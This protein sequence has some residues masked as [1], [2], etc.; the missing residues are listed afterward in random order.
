MSEVVETGGPGT[1]PYY[2][3]PEALRAALDILDPEV[4][5]DEEATTLIETA[6]DLVDDD[7]G[8][9]PVDETTGRRVVLADEAPW[10]LDKLSKATIEV[11]KVL[12]EDPGVERR[13]RHSSVSGDVATSGPYG[14]P[15]GQRYVSLLSASGL[16]VRF[17][18]MGRRRGRNARI[19]ED[20]R[21]AS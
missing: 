2:T 3:T 10:R 16:R 20:F 1:E 4:L 15:F 18:R 21:D 12:Y 19:V 9:R 17:A 11:A 8:N 7:L 14:S 6:E 13:Q 5:P